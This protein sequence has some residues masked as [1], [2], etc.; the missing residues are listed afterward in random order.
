ML[1]FVNILNKRWKENVT[2]FLMESFWNMKTY[3]TPLE[4]WYL[5]Q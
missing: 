5:Q 3:L 2:D 4:L 1:V